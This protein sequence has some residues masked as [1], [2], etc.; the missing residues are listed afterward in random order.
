MGLPLLA[1]STHTPLTT[2]EFAFTFHP[3]TKRH[4]TFD[5]NVKVRFN[6]PDHN[7]SRL[8]TFPYTNDGEREVWFTGPS[9]LMVVSG[10][11]TVDEEVRDEVSRLSKI[12][13]HAAGMEGNAV[14][15]KGVLDK[16][17]SMTWG[18]FT[19]ATKKLSNEMGYTTRF[20]Y[21]PDDVRVRFYLKAL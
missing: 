9:V 20:A 8:V 13:D 15:T 7:T 3:N 10:Y 1:L 18:Q 4:F 12:M 6:G 14:P 16:E 5:P 19:G 2:L 21:L 17:W 11:T